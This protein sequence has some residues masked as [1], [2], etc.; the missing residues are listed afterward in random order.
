VNSLLR[1]MSWKVR[2]TNSRSAGESVKTRNNP[3]LTSRRMK[4]FP[5]IFQESLRLRKK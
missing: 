5:I 2:L 1:S 3:Y 4:F